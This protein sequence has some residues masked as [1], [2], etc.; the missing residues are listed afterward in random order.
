MT[1][2]SVGGPSWISHLLSLPQKE[3]VHLA[4]RFGYVAASQIPISALCS[5]KI[6]GPLPSLPWWPRS[7]LDR[8]HRVLGSITFLLY[9]LHS[10]MM[11]TRLD[12][13]LGWSSLA[14]WRALLV[15]IGVIWRRSVNWEGRAGKYANLRNMLLI[16]IVVWH[17]PALRF[18]AW[19]TGSIVAVAF[20]CRG[21]ISV[22]PR[23]GS[24]SPGSQQDTTADAAS[25]DQYVW[26]RRTNDDNSAHHSYA[27][28]F[29]AS[30]N[31]GMLARTC[32]KIAVSLPSSIRS[33]F[34]FIEAAETSTSIVEF[35]G[36]LEAKGSEKL[37]L[38]CRLPQDY[39][40]NLLR[41]LARSPAANLI[42]VSGGATGSFAYPIY[43]DVLQGSPSTDIRLLL[44][45][46]A[47][48]NAW[49]QPRR[50]MPMTPVEKK[51]D[52]VLIHG[53]ESPGDMA[54][55]QYMKQVVEEAVLHATGQLI[56]LV[57]GPEQI[58]EE[59]RK[60]CSQLVMM[61]GAVLLLRINYEPKTA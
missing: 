56:I 45:L 43:L 52:A 2:S 37:A 17:A 1:E 19:E 28:A 24:T 51:A 25:T 47:K 27:A 14:L 44:A 48:S 35:S 31:S 55:E 58:A 40:S 53:S 8:Y 11:L 5:S 46:G 38:F 29:T 23:E 41:V 15:I 50:V 26:I 60:H 18:Y 33:L 32:S 22:S 36:K 6:V 16:A 9:S 21:S 3:V 20:G 12:I 57:V 61:D 10:A 30:I 39:S 34:W 54:P 49:P 13:G 4:N 42:I 59:V 7:Q